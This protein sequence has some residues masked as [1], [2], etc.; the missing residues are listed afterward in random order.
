VRE[1]R[2][3]LYENETERLLVIGRYER[4]D[5][6]EIVEAQLLPQRFSSTG[7]ESFARN[8]GRRN[9]IDDNTDQPSAAQAHAND[10]TAAQ[11]EAFGQPIIERS[12][13]GNGKRDAGDGHDSG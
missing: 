1:R 12:G 9:D 11:V 10:R 7:C 5:V 2:N 8:V 6:D 13:C 4:R 3:H